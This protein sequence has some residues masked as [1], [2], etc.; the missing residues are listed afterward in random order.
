[1]EIFFLKLTLSLS[2][3]HSKQV[4]AKFTFIKVA[5][6]TRQIGN[7]FIYHQRRIISSNNYLQLGRINTHQLAQNVIL[8]ANILKKRLFND[9]LVTSIARTKFQL[10]LYLLKWLL[11]CQCCRNRI[12][13]LVKVTLKKENGFL[14]YHRRMKIIQLNS[15]LPQSVT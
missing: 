10:S 11:R 1:M 7:N 6:E 4:P 15:N 12:R 13:R 14:Y 3:L 2:D 9:N 8:K 5:V